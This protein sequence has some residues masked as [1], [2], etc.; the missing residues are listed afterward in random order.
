MNVYI[1][2]YFAII[3][4]L[5]AILT[6]HDKSAARKN[7][8]RVKERTLLAVSVLGGS[9]AMLLS[10][11]AVRHKTQ[12]KKFMVGI[13]L[14][15]MVQALIILFA[16]NHSLSVSHYSLSALRASNWTSQFERR[17]PIPRL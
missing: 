6:F 17:R 16:F 12:R 7:T 4:L 9:V 15:I 10:M 1:L 13:P 14:I 5:S 3:S 11:V 8:W 2:L